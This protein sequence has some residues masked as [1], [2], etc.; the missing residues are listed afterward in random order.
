[1][2][3]Q[4]NEQTRLLREILKWIKFAGMKEL[5]NTL[6]SVLDTDAKKIVYQKS[7]GTNGTV[8]LAK[9]AGYGSNKTIADLW[10]DWLKL[11]LGER[12]AV[13]GGS[14]FKRSFDLNDFG[15]ETPGNKRKS[16]TGKDAK[17]PKEAKM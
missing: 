17:N 7:D 4:E 15:I 13:K 10:N 14:R 3:P 8:K 6:L 9:L 11:S 5:K 16:V 12:I 1:M 2:N